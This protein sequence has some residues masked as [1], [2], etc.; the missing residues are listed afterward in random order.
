MR[1][2]TVDIASEIGAVGE[3]IRLAFSEVA[4][5]L[6]FTRENSPGFTA[7]ASDEKLLRQLDRPEARCLG[8]REAGRWVGFVAVAPYE[9]EFIVTRLAVHPDFRH[10][11]YGRA[12]MDAACEAARAM[13]LSEIGLGVLNENAV[14]KRW[15]EAQGFVADEPYPVPGAAYSACG[16]SKKLG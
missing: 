16:M 1:I 12:L 7:F 5:R 14:L 6:G 15:Y 13:G 8:I 10:R 4:D 11:G 9:D 2:E 3:L